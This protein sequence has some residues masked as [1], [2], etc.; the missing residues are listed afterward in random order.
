MYWL[1]RLNPANKFKEHFELWQA[2]TPELRDGVYRLRYRV[3]VDE[4]GFER[5][6]FDGRECDEFDEHYRHLLLR[7]LKTGIR[8]GCIRLVMARPD[9]PHLPLSLEKTSP[10]RVT[11]AIDLC[12]CRATRSRRSRGSLSPIGPGH[13]GAPSLRQRL[14]AG[15]RRGARPSHDGAIS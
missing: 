8:A 1:H 9:R 2:L 3:Y 11:L 12:C 5:P 13:A 15:A 14:I 7:S 4:L 10:L 6:S